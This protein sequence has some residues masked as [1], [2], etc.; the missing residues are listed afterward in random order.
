MPDQCQWDDELKLDLTQSRPV[1][2]G[3]T[4]TIPNGREPKQLSA[5]ELRHRS[6]WR[7]IVLRE[8]TG[9]S[10]P[11][12]GAQNQIAKWLLLV[13]EGKLE[14]VTFLV[15]ILIFEQWNS[16]RAPKSAWGA[17]TLRE[18]RLKTWESRSCRQSLRHHLLASAWWWVREGCECGFQQSYCRA[19][20]L[21]WAYHLLAA[22]ICSHVKTN[23]DILW[24]RNQHVAIYI[25]IIRRCF[26]L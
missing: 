8:G 18:R 16:R 15:C 9:I 19:G 12:G 5:W 23:W 26:I 21:P 14:G 24:A 17:A 6:W 4:V 10:K 1:R 22:K 3:E 11:T 7:P 13:G 2:W 25:F 20:L